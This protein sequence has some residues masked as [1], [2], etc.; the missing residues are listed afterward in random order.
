MAVSSDPHRNTN[1]FSLS[2]CQQR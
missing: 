2:T 1:R